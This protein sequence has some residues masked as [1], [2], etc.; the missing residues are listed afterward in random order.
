AVVARR[1][2][3]GPEV[4][5]ALD[6]ATGVAHVVLPLAEVDAGVWD[7][8]LDEPG[9]VDGARARLSAETGLGPPVRVGDR[10][11]EPYRTVKGNLSLRLRGLRPRADVAAV[12]PGDGLLTVRARLHEVEGAVDAVVGVSRHGH[13]E[14]LVP[15]QHAD[16]AVQARLPLDRLATVPGLRHDTVDL[17]VRLRRPGGETQDLR[18]RHPATGQAPPT[19]PIL[20]VRAGRD[21]VDLQAYY[22][23]KGNLSVRLGAGSPPGVGIVP[24]A[25][26]R[27]PAPAPV[28]RLVEAYLGRVR[29]RNLAARR[30][31][32]PPLGTDRPRVYLLMR[33]AYGVGGTIR[34][35]VT[36]ANHLAEQGYRV[37][38]ISLLRPK[39]TTF[40]ALHPRI[41][42]T[43]LFDERTR[44]GAVV[45]L[46]TGEKP[47]R[48]LARRALS[49][50]LDGWESVLT[51][52]RE[53]A[54]GRS[55]LLTDLLLVRKLQRLKPGVLVLT[56][57]VLNVVGARFAPPQV[58]TV[59]QEHMNFTL[60]PPELSAW[61]L[62]AYR[63]LDVLTVLTEGDARD[64]RAALDGTGVDVRRIP[65]GLPRLPERVSDQS[66][67]VV[68]AAGRLTRQKGFDLLVRA[69]AEVAAR[70]PDWQLRIFGEG[71]EQ[72]ALQRAIRDLGLTGSVWLMGRTAQV[73]DE[74]ARA[75]LYALSSRFEG[76]GMV[77][78]EA[79]S[80]GLP[81]V[82]F[83]CPRGPA[84]I[85][86]HGQDGLLVP[87]EDVGALAQALLRLIEDDDLRQTMA[88]AARSTAQDYAMDRLGRLWESLLGDLAREPGAPSAE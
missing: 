31:G 3:D 83:D 86:T 60:H 69:F 80:A 76:F 62:D 32:R 45:T 74:M 21:E 14:L 22:T 42:H 87:A 49:A 10:V 23:V 67:K 58:R 18:L 9:G 81:V 72:E 33:S 52:P 20:R 63:H 17:H 61:M 59:G 78:I 54:F 40:F 13:R 34:T 66:A 84:D 41:R 75:S 38:L 39:E 37:E 43:W 79:M 16:D 77:I 26:P 35:V 12:E 8:Y 53:V 85:V 48:A 27:R 24:G 30:R 70:R 25:V 51:H 47:V 28:R 65:N 5:A 11:L 29:R 50:R 73:P 82:A 57:P 36:T 46:V 2:P 88:S 4:D 56:R 55:S 15:A 6:P 1:R 7:L 68:V 19:F 44:Y 71:A 64:Y